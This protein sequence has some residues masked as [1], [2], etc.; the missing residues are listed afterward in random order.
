MTKEEI[1]RLEELDSIHR[2]Q[3]ECETR[4]WHE[5]GSMGDHAPKRNWFHWSVTVFA[6]LVI[7][8]AL[9]MLPSIARRVNAPVEAK[10]HVPTTTELGQQTCAVHN[11]SFVTWRVVSNGVTQVF[12]RTGD[13]IELTQRFIRAD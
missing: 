11:Q 12:C 13:S 7:V 3:Y 4:M 8:A 2:E 9:V 6:V 1:E 5:Y 10:P